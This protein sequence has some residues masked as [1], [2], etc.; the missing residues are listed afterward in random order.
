MPFLKQTLRRYQATPV[1]QRREYL[2]AVKLLQIFAQQLAGLA[3]QIVLLQAD[4][5]PVQITQAREL[6]AAQYQE[7]ITLSMVSKQVGMNRYSFCKSFK[8]ATG[9]SYTDFVSRV[10]LEKAKIL[11]LNPQYRISEIAFEVGFKSRRILTGSS[12][13][14]PEN[15]RQNT[16]N[17]SQGPESPAP[18][19]NGCNSGYS[20]NSSKSATGGD[21]ARRVQ[22]SVLQY[23]ACHS[24]V[25]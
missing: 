25:F 14:S 19:R 22:A 12:G 11:L 20:S 24:S 3:N 18:E 15:R 23:F 8:Q 10:R 5:E 9:A 16:V 7:D 6:I 13:E 21:S 17:I 1:V 4:V 2:A